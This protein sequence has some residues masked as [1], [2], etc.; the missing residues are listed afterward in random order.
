MERNYGKMHVGEVFLCVQMCTHFI[1]LQLLLCCAEILLEKYAV[2][3]LAMPST[4]VVKQNF[5]ST[6]II[7]NYGILIIHKFRTN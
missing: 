2:L 3:Q 7:V 4:L 5:P 6:N 1:F